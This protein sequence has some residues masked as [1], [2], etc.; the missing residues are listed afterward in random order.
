MQSS[1]QSPGGLIETYEHC[2]ALPYHVEPAN[3]DLKETE[4][5]FLTADYKRVKSHN[6]HQYPNSLRFF[7][8]FISVPTRRLHYCP[9][10]IR[11]SNIA[12]CP[13]PYPSH[14]GLFK[15]P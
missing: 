5:F 9:V 6:S 8:S 2:P 12:H 4:R 13:A 11:Y 10:Q 15:M 1:A 14:A 3:L 7:E